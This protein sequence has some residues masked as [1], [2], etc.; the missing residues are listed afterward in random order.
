MSKVE[1]RMIALQMMADLKSTILT[2]A[3]KTIV[4]INRCSVPKCNMSACFST[5]LPATAGSKKQECEGNC[6]VELL[7]QSNY[8]PDVQRDQGSLNDVLAVRNAIVVQIEM[9]IFMKRILVV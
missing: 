4:D 1:S 2:L 6:T 8:T 5:S 9:S 7:D 3:Q